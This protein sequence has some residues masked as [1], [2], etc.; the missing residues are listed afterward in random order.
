MTFPAYLLTFSLVCLTACSQVGT[1]STPGTPNTP[2]GSGDPGT[3]EA[4]V[5]KGYVTNA[6]GAPLE[7]V[8]VF[9]D[10]TLEYNSNI[11]GVTDASG[12]YRLD[13]P[14]LATT[15]NAGAYV[16]P[17]FEGQRY[18]FRLV[19]DDENAF[20]GVDGA[21]RNFIWQ[22]SGPTPDGSGDYGATVYV[23]GEY[24]SGDFE[25]DNVELTLAPE[26]LLIDGSTGQTLTQTPVGGE[27]NDVP[28]GRYTVSGRYVDVS[29]AERT[30]LLADRNG[31]G[32]YQ[33]T[34]S[35]AFGNDPYYGLNIELLVQVQ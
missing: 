23:Y 4:Y 8:E 6:Q 14:A 7:G 10:N 33:Q 3:V 32:S 20:A 35:V 2:G 27:I 9:A 16:R 22:L 5:M 34:Q 30:V 26:G 19:P 28:I 21:V 18:E 24:A 11:L 12:F 1:P 31:D 13:L 29:G 17:T 25:V 15:W